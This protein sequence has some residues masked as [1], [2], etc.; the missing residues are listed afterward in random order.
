[1][2]NLRMNSLRFRLVLLL[3][4]GLSAAWL[5]AAWFTYAESREE[6]DQLFDAQLAQSA[7]VL[8]GTTRHELHER[9]EHGDDELASSHEYA[10]KLAFQIWDAHGLLMRSATAPDTKM[11]GENEGYSVS[12]INAEPWRVFTRWDTH[13]EFMIQVAEPMSG[14][15]YLAQHIT[16][17][18]LMPALIALPVLATLIWFGVGVGLRPLQQLKQEVAQRSVNRLDAVAIINVPEEVK[19]LIQALNDLFERLKLAFESEQRFTADAAHELRT[20][21]AALKVQAQ[22]ALRSNQEAE[23]HDALENVVRGVERA[24]R[25]IAQLLA[26]AR[27]DPEAAAIDFKPLELNTLLGVVLRELAPMAYAKQIEITLEN[28][29]NSTVLGNDAQLSLLFRNLIDNAIR[30]TPRGGRVSVSV[31]DKKGVCVEV[32]DTGAGIPEAQ[33]EQ[34]LGRFYRIAGSGEEGS[35]L[36]LSIARRIAELHGAQLLLS[37]RPQGTGL[38]VKVCWESVRSLGCS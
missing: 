9:I 33:R 21:L 8:L 16:L 7:Q 4:L 27:V 14:R 13:H 22:V 11:A 10:L 6:M 30:Y 37:N 12:L 1:M 3:L 36:G 24:T 15:S 31:Q 5:V 2:K 38:L 35:G 25:L 29:S 23:R 19:P 20:P 28:E 32:C 17:K 18:M 34:V 26:L